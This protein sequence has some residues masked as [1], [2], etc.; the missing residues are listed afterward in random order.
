MYIRSP[1]TQAGNS[2][3]KAWGV[4]GVGQR[5]AKEG[6]MGTSI[7]LSTK[8]YMFIF[9][10]QTTKEYSWEAGGKPLCKV[11]QKPLQWPPTGECYIIHNRSPIY[12][13][14]SGF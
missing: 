5:G 3:A 11:S 6:K 13:I 9:V 8:K 2:V 12:L 4:A 7:I 1:W 14:R 10:K